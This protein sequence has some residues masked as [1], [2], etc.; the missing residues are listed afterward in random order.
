MHNPPK[1]SR[2]KN[3][4]ETYIC[5]KRNDDMMMRYEI[6]MTST[7]PW[8]ALHLILTILHLLVLLYL[9]SKCLLVF[10]MVEARVNTQRNI[11]AVVKVKIQIT[12]GP[13]TAATLENV[14]VRVVKGCVVC[15][16]ALLH[17]MH[18]HC[19]PRVFC[20]VQPITR[21]ESE[22]CIWWVS[23][24]WGYELSITDNVF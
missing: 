1:P 24:T 5:K 7:T 3:P 4:S 17:D 15:Q 16:R 2:F 14:G 19:I 23:L 18:R 21:L 13:A 22:R 9:L 10:F 20:T 12:P 8:Y 6:F 11:I